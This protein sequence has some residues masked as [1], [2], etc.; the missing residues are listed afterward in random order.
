M[1]VVVL[2][3]LFALGAGSAV[4]QD[5]GNMAVISSSLGNNSNRLCIGEGSRPT[6]I[7]CPTYAPYVS[8]TGNVAIGTNNPANFML[9]ISSSTISNLDL[10]R[11]TGSGSGEANIAFKTAGNGSAQIRGLSSGGLRITDYPAGTEW[12]RVTGSGIGMFTATP[13]TALEVSGTVSATRFVGDGSGLTGIASAATTDR[14][15]SGTTSMLAVSATG[16][17]SLTQ[18]GVNTGWFDPARG[19]VTIGI[20]ST[21]P[22]SATQVYAGNFGATGSVIYRDANGNLTADTSVLA[23]SHNLYANNFIPANAAGIFWGTGSDKIS[24]DNSVGNHYVAITTSG[25]EAM[26]IVSSGFVGI[27]TSAPS[28]SVHVYKPSGEANLHLTSA[29][30]STNA[31]V[32]LEG[33]SRIWQVANREADLGAAFAI[34]D[35][36]AAADRLTIVSSG[37]VGIGTTAP[38]ANLQIVRTGTA[39]AGLSVPFAI[40]NSAGA[41]AT[42]G[43]DIIG[44]T[45]GATYINFGNTTTQNLGSIWYTASNTLSFGTN[46][47]TNRVVINSLG[48]TG[49]GTVT[50][51]TALEVSGTVSATNFVGNGSGLTGVTASTDRIVSGSI[52]AVADVS[53]GAVRVSGTLALNNTG[54]EPCDAA[55]WFTFRANPVTQQMQMCRP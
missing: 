47:T 53:T 34:R 2:A 22:I 55:H 26:R 39:V 32:Y 16:Y 17:V 29:A 35:Q 49:I 46:G 1:R 5:W 10:E 37:N 12:M 20:S 30:A 11:N 36:T 45:A 27:G 41:S 52:N 3:L 42:A 25:T 31:R 8:S 13:T 43:M 24:G 28:D 18:S 19:L 40:Q 21:G 33:A 38:S 23:G 14:I 50:P 7:G 54:S 51:T 44:G 9:T 4:A 48:N 15:V 6:D